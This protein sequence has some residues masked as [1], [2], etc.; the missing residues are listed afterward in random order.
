MPKQEVPQL[1]P[2]DHQASQHAGGEDVCCRGL[3]FQERA[4]P[5]EVPTRESRALLSVDQDAR[6]AF[7]DHIEAAAL[8]SRPDH[9]LSVPEHL[10]SAGMRN[11]LE[12]RPAEVG[13]ERELLEHACEIRGARFHAEEPTGVLDARL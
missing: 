4:L 10:L 5:E 7:H 6:L 2:V 3:F 9:A 12:L 11:R 8:E 13:E 1:W